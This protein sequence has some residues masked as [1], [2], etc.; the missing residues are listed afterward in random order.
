MTFSCPVPN[1]PIFSLTHYKAAHRKQEAV[2]TRC[3]LCNLGKQETVIGQQ[4]NN[5]TPYRGISCRFPVCSKAEEKHGRGCDFSVSDRSQLQ[6]GR[7]ARGRVRRVREGG[8]G[9]L[10]ELTAVLGR[11]ESG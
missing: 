10:T 1:Y 8:G 9:S 11:G 2:C 5:Y 4:L 6:C 7:T 3:P